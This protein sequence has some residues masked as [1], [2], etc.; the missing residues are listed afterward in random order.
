MRKFLKK[1]AALLTA[2]F[3]CA[4]NI[5]SVSA[6]QSHLMYSQCEENVMHLYFNLPAEKMKVGDA[7]ISDEKVKILEFSQFDKDTQVK[8]V[9][10]FDRAVVSGRTDI[11]ST[12]LP[13]MQEFLM[14]SYE[15]ESFDVVSYGEGDLSGDEDLSS[16]ANDILKNVENLTYE[17]SSKKTLS[18]AVEYA[19]EKLRKEDDTVFKKIIV[20]TDSDSVNEIDTSGDE[21]DYI[22]PVYYI[23]FDPEEKAIY[24]DKI[25]GEGFYSEYYKYTKETTISA[26][27][28]VIS[29]NSHLYHCKIEIP[30]EML[31]K[32]GE[33]LLSI[34]FNGDGYSAS[35]E[36]SVMIEPCY[37]YVMEHENANMK[38]IIIIIVSA[39]IV[40]TAVI[41]IIC[42]KRIKDGRQKQ[43]DTLT[44]VL[45]HEPL[46]T[47]TI[48]SA[49]GTR[50]LF[51]ECRYK[52]ILIDRQN[53]ENVF[54]T[55]VETESFVGRN[56]SLV[57]CAI[58]NEPSI[59]QKHCKFFVRDTKL[60]ITDLG[61][62]NHTYVDG[63]QVTDEAEVIDGS[64]I[65]LGR[66]EFET[67]VIRV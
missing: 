29:S 33:R 28:E 14:R 2:A 32:E 61:S 26:I 53:S 60:F 57:D 22:Y 17:N 62:L 1:T 34:D 4:S 48:P 51:R 43:V 19:N 59:S 21:D 16:S 10:L 67:R 47:R 37:D 49:Q 18:E 6:A 11:I 41:I 44:T 7:Y 27:P 25:S 35:V 9:F 42:K 30:F 13:V 52:V 15:N 50:V 36:K 40:L 45:P 31:K 3:M 66:S 8:T 64:T 38:K 55:I 39:F 63:E 65:K 12:Y 23:L 46:Q 54:E 24:T 56:H 20:F 58:T 5:L